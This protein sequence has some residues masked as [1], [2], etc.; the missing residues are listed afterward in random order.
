M[1]VWLLRNQLSKTADPL[2]P[3]RLRL[4]ALAFAVLSLSTGCVVG[5]AA[6]KPPAA[7]ATKAPTSKPS[8][9]AACEKAVR[10]EYHKALEEQTDGRRPRVCN[11][12][13]QAELKEIVVRVI[14]EETPEL[15]THRAERR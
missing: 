7:T 8:K 15:P 5:T 9:L 11:G 4:P 12:I 2:A 14:G 10:R 6:V 13:P 1:P 3:V